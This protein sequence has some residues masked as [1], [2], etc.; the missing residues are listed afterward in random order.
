MTRTNNRALANTPHNFVSVLDFGADPSGT[1]DSIQAFKD[2]LTFIQDNLQTS[3]TAYRPSFLARTL[4][5]PTGEYQLS[6]ALDLRQYSISVKGEGVAST[7][8]FFTNASSC[9][10]KLD[11]VN[12]NP[13]SFGHTISDLSITGVY[14]GNNSLNSLE[15]YELETGDTVGISVNTL[16]RLCT[17]KD[18]HVAGFDI[19]LK[20][21]S[22]WST[23]YERCEFWN[24]A[25]YGVY[26]NACGQTTWSQCRFDSNGYGFF[27]KSSE[28][29]KIFSCIFQANKYCGTGVRV[30][31]DQIIFNGCYWEFNGGS[32]TVFENDDGESYGLQA[33]VRAV[34]AVFDGS[35]WTMSN[36]PTGTN[37]VGI[38]SHCPVT[39]VNGAYGRGASKTAFKAYGDYQHIHGGIFD[40]SFGY[41]AGT[42]RQS[43]VTGTVPASGNSVG[44]RPVTTHTGI[45]AF[46]PE[47]SRGVG[48]VNFYGKIVKSVPSFN[49]SLADV[50]IR[51]YLGSGSSGNN[52]CPIFKLTIAQGHG[53][54][55][56]TLNYLELVCYLKNSTRSDPFL[57][58]D[59]L[60]DTDNKWSTAVV[61]NDNVITTGAN[62]LAG[63]TDIILPVNPGSGTGTANSM[64]VM[65]EG[66]SCMD[67]AIIDTTTKLDLVTGEAPVPPVKPYLLED[68]DS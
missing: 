35:Y 17:F 42:T 52:I 8:I 60:Q 68:S 65:A 14:S 53:V 54:A 3:Q 20:G 45:F 26:L 48:K 64:W 50:T 4:Y 66:S 33:D 62:Q 16:I 51:L 34:S 63:Y 30:R 55:V 41:Y 25:K 67:L 44:I 38:S 32:R 43:L 18:I 29:L 31:C 10:I 40:S 7:N 21:D 9:G 22:S 36:Q 24:N 28:T 56:S 59:A 58:I 15:E 37:V 61:D 49:N 19:G 6:E 23:I 39:F 57:S 5:I 47:Y 12:N 2:A 11:E 27:S 13:N 1:T 46:N